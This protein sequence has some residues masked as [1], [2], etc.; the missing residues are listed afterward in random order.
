MS[1]EVV[2]AYDEVVAQLQERHRNVD[3]FLLL[4]SSMLTRKYPQEKKQRFW[5]S[6][7]Y[8]HDASEEEVSRRIQHMV[9]LIPVSHGHGRYEIV[10]QTGLDTV[11][12]MAS[13]D[14]IDTVAGEV[15]PNAYG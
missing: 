8:Q 5:L 9:G 1:I 12:A 6:V 4:K 3:P 13:L 11:L 10:L 15:Y 2:K 7:Q 14:G